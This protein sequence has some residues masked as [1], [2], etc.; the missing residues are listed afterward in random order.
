MA[1][2]GI[3]LSEQFMNIRKSITLILSVPRDINI[4]T[5]VAKLSDRSGLEVNYLVHLQS[6][7]SKIF[8]Y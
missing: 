8:L 6:F 7:A 1:K 2:K 3:L 4:H 5:F